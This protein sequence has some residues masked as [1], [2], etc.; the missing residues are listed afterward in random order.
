MRVPA[1]EDVVQTAGTDEIGGQV[2]RHL[3]RKAST[4]PGMLGNAVRFR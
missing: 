1:R 3:D 2:W 4:G